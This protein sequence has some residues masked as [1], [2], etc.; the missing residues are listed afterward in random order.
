MSGRWF[1][2]VATVGVNIGHSPHQVGQNVEKTIK[3]GTDGV[4]KGVSGHTG[5]QR[6][7]LTTS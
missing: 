4:T 7:R 1:H 3:K 2:P 5:Q 6:Q